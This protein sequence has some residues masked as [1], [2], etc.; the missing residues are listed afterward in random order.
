MR[1]I[2][3]LPIDQRPKR[4]LIEFARPERRDQSRYRPPE[5]RLLTHAKPPFRQAAQRTPQFQGSLSSKPEQAHKLKQAD[6]T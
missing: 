3:D 2:F 4:G 1:A 6:D 5:R